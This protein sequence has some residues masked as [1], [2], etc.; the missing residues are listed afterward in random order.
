MIDVR[1]IEK[2]MKRKPRPVI[3]HRL[4]GIRSL[5]GDDDGK[6]DKVLFDVMEFADWY[7]FQSEFSLF[8]FKDHPEVKRRGIDLVKNSMIHNGV[9]QSIF[10]P[11]GDGLAGLVRA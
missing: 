4:D 11:G 10:N 7:I 2:V 3:I 9:D 1:D 6:S 5:Y 8:Q